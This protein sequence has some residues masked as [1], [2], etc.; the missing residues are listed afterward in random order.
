MDMKWTRNRVFKITFITLLIGITVLSLIPPSSGIELG[1]YDKLNHLIA[2][3]I[4][5]LN[6]GMLSLSIKKWIIAALMCV[7][8]GVLIEFFQ[9]FVPGRDPSVFDAVVNAL[10]VGLG[11][12]SV[13]LFQQFRN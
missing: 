4:L 9:G 8:Y 5:S 2:Y 12:L 7:F 13:V 6:L 3:Y 10:G 11:M 1:A